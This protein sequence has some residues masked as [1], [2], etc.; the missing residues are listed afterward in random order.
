MGA[1][2]KF[3]R[4]WI[5][6][7]QWGLER[8]GRL[9]AR[10]GSSPVPAPHLLTGL[11]GEEAATFELRRRGVVVV[12]RRWTSPKM[13]GD[14]DLIGWDGDCLCFIEVK[15]RTARDL[16]PAESAVDEEKRVMVR[17][18]AR[19]YLRTLP[20]SERA[21]ARVRFDVVSVYSI[22]GASEFEVFENAFGW[23]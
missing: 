9:G 12:A 5:G 14:L 20:E 23:Q 22:D 7:Q 10:Q 11:R 3:E 15:T 6:A 18:L 16:S 1:A 13:R 4:R 21:T 17:N 2:G 19:A 8:L